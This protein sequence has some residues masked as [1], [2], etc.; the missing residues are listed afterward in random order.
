MTTTVSLVNISTCG[1]G[2]CFLVMRPRGERG[3][4]GHRALAKGSPPGWACCDAQDSIGDTVLEAVFI[5]T[6]S[7][8]KLE[9][10]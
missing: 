10:F 9:A 6:I 7:F 1:T 2:F 5:S 8:E 4:P 3:V